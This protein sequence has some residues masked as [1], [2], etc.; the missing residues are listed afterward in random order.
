[1]K[2][3]GEIEV[4]KVVN[5]GNKGLLRIYYLPLEIQSGLQYYIYIESEIDRK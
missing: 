2:L 5:P 4:R 3:H 1:M